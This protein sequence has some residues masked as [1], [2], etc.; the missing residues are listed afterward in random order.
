MMPNNIQEELWLNQTQFGNKKELSSLTIHPGVVFYQH[1]L[2]FMQFSPGSSCGRSFNEMS[3]R[4][5]L[6]SS[7]FYASMGFECNIC[8]I[9]LIIKFFSRQTFFMLR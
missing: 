2:V 9:T 6:C 3:D 5:N 1:H 4:I 8:F 7:A